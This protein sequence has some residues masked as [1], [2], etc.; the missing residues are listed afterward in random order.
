MKDVESD[1]LIVVEY[2]QRE[3][4]SYVMKPYES[5]VGGGGGGGGGGR[6]G[7]RS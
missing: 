6:G 5:W 2:S 3:S 1:R 7:I 4:W